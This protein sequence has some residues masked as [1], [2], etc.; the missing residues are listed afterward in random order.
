MVH[1][2]NRTEKIKPDMNNKRTE[3]QEANFQ[4]RPCLV[5]TTLPLL[6]VAAMASTMESDTM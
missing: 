1:Y 5:N 4:S 6:I 3:Q 2:M